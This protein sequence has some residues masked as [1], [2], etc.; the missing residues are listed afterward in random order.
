MPQSHSLKATVIVAIFSHHLR[1]RSD[2]LRDPNRLYHLR[3]AWRFCVSLW[4][5]HLTHSFQISSPQ[6]LGKLPSSAKTSRIHPEKR[7]NLRSGRRRKF[8][9]SELGELHFLSGNHVTFPD[10]RFT[11][12]AD[13]PAK[14]T[15]S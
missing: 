2:V 14:A 4:T 6:K 13:Y 3:S 1:S 12:D 11:S 9:C 7:R 8:H 5:S 10:L 15:S